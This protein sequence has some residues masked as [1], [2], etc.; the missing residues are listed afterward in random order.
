LTVNAA[1]KPLDPT[2]IE[3]LRIKG[4][5]CDKATMD[6]TWKNLKGEEKEYQLFI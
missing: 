1:L 6:C 3:E 2:D 5:Y 4:E